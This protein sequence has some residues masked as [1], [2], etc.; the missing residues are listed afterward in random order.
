MAPKTLRVTSAFGRTLK[1]AILLAYH[2]DE[3]PKGIRRTFLLRLQGDR[4]VV[5]EERPYLLGC[6]WYSSSGTTYC[7]VVDSGAIHRWHAGQW[8][9]E[10]FSSKPAEVRY[11]YVVPGAKPEDDTVFLAGEKQLFVRQAGKWLSKRIPGQGFPFQVTGTSADQVYVGASE[12]SVWDGKKLNS[13]E[14]PD[15][16]S[17]SGLAL[18]A[19]DRLIGGNDFISASTSDGGWERIPTPFKGVFMFA[20]LGDDVYALTD[21]QGVAKVY[22]GP[23]QS[24]TRPLDALGLLAVGDGLIAFGRDGVLAFDGTR[25]FEVH[26]PSCELGQAPA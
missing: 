6:A 19:D 24:F 5:L 26:M 4:A 2:P 21:K 8:S 22:P 20:R 14:S 15:D 7:S 1:E 23:I 13:L 9:E 12:L 18:T 3:Y 25:W 11:V 17:M 10:T 16:D